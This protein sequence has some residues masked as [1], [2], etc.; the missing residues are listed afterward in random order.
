MISHLVNNFSL[1]ATFS[2][3]PPS[4]LQRRLTQFRHEFQQP[5]QSRG[6]MW[7]MTMT[8][9]L[10]VTNMD[11]GKLSTGQWNYYSEQRS[12]VRKSITSYVKERVA[13]KYVSV[14]NGSIHLAKVNITP[15][16]PLP[17]SPSSPSHP[18]TYSLYVFSSR[19]NN[20]GEA[21]VERARLFSSLS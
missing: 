16:S 18:P 9:V 19:R 10:I 13:T 21:F 11:R 5:A 2:T 12:G 15:Q 7:T 20:V 17:V 1:T 3:L 4:Q 8:V 14:F 6:M